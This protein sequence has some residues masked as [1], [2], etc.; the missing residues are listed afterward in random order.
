MMIN[1][2]DNQNINILQLMDKLQLPHAKL[3]Y[4]VSELWKTKEID[5]T[6]KK[7]LK[8]KIISDEP[9]IFE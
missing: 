6:E 2:N 7:I 1:D 4:F 5:E 3:L 8:E 9:S